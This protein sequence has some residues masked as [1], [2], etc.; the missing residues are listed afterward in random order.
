MK[1]LRMLAGC[2]GPGTN[3]AASAAPPNLSGQP[4]VLLIHGFKDD[5]RKMERLRCHLEAQGFRAFSVTLRPSLGQVGLE[6]LGAQ[7]AAFVDQTFGSG[8]P[9]D[10]VG[11]S[12][13]GLVARYYV[14][15]LGGVDRVRRLVTLASPHR[16]TLLAWCIPNPGCRQMRPGSKFLRSLDADRDWLRRVEVTSLL[17]PLDLMIVP[18]WSSRMDGARNLTKWVLAHPLMVSQRACLEAVVEVLGARA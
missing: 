12:M 15:Q 13:G 1:R 8:E 11:F 4:P 2:F 3:T 16:G 9:L 18:S 6:E 7:V 17:T 5:A 10:L 14:Q